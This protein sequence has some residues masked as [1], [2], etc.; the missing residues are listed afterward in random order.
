MRLSFRKMMSLLLSLLMVLGLFA[1][2]S[3]DVEET[4]QSPNTQAQT[5][6]KPAVTEPPEEAD[7]LKILTLGHSLAL[8]CGHLLA[9]IA[10]TEG[11]GNL[12]VGTLYY[13]GC[14]LNKHVEFME[15]DLP[16]YDLYLSSTNTAKTPP[17]VTEGVT[18]RQAV[19]F[20]Y[21]DIIIM[22][23][24]VFEIA[25]DA[26]YKSG[27]IQ[28]IQAFVN[29]NKINPN[30]YF[31]WNSPW[32]PPTDNTLRDKYP[33]ENNPYYS[34]YTIYGDDRTVFF[35]SVSECLK[36]NIL[37]GD[38]FKFLIPSG[39]AIENAVTSYL[40]E[41]DI[42]RD[43]VHASDFSRVIASYVW[44]C[45]L[46][47]IEQLEE[48][49]LDVIPRNFFKSTV[50]V[51]DRVLTDMEKAIILESVNNALKEPLKITQSQYTEAPTT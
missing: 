31:A 20:D 10:E 15:K 42:H 32:A 18:L 4:A 2:C 35:E 50:G 41:K 7:T 3:A 51:E 44:Y 45:K 38:T 19:Q 12:V 30:A 1:G 43:Y 17:A 37:T 14:P 29:E 16:E 36:N 24:G 8:D 40:E 6:D 46:A 34:S 22:Q 9:L 13:S 26:T 49:K 33:Y 5:S 48:I 21:W 11:F 39:T 27:N 25:E 28:K 47:G 23:G